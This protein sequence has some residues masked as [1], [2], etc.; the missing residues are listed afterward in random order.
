MLNDERKEKVDG[1]EGGEGREVFE[2]DDPLA[3]TRFSISMSFSLRFFLS[4]A[5]SFKAG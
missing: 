3:A 2:D 4:K 1:D 5:S